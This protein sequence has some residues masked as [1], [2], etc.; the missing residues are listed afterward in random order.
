MN[1]RL[2]LSSYAYYWAICAKLEQGVAPMTAW[3][4]VNKTASLDLEVVQICENLPLITWDKRSLEQLR[5]VALRQGITLEIGVRGLDVDLLR[6]HLD[7]THTLSAHVLRVVPWSGSETQQKLSLDKLHRVVDQI[8]PLCQEH[9]ITLAI[10]NY[11][12]LPDQEL[13]DFVQQVNDER[14]GVCLDTAN[15]TGFLEKPLKTV[16]VLAPHVVSLHLKDFVV[17][18]PAMGYRISGVPL[19]Q[20]WLDARAVLDIV[21]Q[22]GRQPHVL[23]ELWVDPDET[24]KATLRKEDDWVRQNVAYAR[25]ELGLAGLRTP[26]T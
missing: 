1:N 6:L 12:D 25:D 8:L 23:L 11:F 4:L 16:Q 20:G 15:S 2:G 18:K 26:Q 22:T 7:L 13:A 21:S 3:D 19:G 24:H 9:D 17:T 14:V 10:E 5:D